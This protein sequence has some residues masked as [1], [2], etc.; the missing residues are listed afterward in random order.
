[1]SVSV[2]KRV[3]EE[4]VQAVR[5]VCGHDINFI[6]PSG[7]IFASTNPDRPRGRRQKPVRRWKC[8]GRRTISARSRA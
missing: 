1:M 3:A 2:H 6:S 7:R 4:I 8:T 5:D